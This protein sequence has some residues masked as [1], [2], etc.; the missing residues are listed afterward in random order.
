VTWITARI[1]DH[2]AA[3]DDPAVEQFLADTFT[4]MARVPAKS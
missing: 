4:D 1:T 3:D 2:V